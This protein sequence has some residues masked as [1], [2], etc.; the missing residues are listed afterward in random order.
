ML[1]TTLLAP[2]TRVLLLELLLWLLLGQ[3]F[4][5]LHMHAVP[6]LLLPDTAPD[7]ESKTGTGDSNW[8]SLS[9]VLGQEGWRAN[10]W[11]FGLL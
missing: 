1:L 2:L 9:H 3:R 6:S 4:T 11:H 10:S 7:G 8:Q 5:Y